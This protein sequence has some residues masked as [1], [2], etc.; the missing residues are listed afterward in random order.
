MVFGEGDAVSGWMLVGEAP[1]AREDQSGRPF[2]G[3]AGQILTRGLEA[4]GVSR[5]S[6]F[7]TSVV[8]CRPPKNRL[9]GR[10]EVAACLPLLRQQLERIR[11]GIVVCLG[12]LASRTLLGDPKLKVSEAR[13]T[14]FRKD[15]MAIM[16][17]FHPAAIL[18]NRHKMDEFAGDL[19][20]AAEAWKTWATLRAHQE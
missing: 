9:P 18:R 20:Q 15:G 4:A 10:A 17:V 8:K 6:V 11:P 2:V 16:P 3:L 1:G 12:S 13:G 14:W 19:Q 5:D 7:I